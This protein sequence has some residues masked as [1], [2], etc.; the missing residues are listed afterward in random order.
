MNACWVAAAALQP[1]GMTS[2]GGRT[3]GRVQIPF[4][5]GQ[6]QAGWIEFGGDDWPKWADRLAV[7]TEV[8]R[9][10]SVCRGSSAATL[11]VLTAS[12]SC[13]TQFSG[14]PPVGRRLVL[15]VP[16]MSWHPSFG[17]AGTWPLDL[18][19]RRDGPELPVRQ[20]SKHGQAWAV[21]P[22]HRWCSQQ[23]GHD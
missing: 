20:Q 17:H 14:L 2:Q 11:S 12:R 1:A 16:F 13:N 21:D 4:G 22:H 9:P 5:L 18:A 7:V 8:R 19:G 10:W 15:P 3:H 6:N 23:N